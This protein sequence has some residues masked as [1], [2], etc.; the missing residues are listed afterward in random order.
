MGVIPSSKMGRQLSKS[1]IPN[2]STSGNKL[3]FTGYL[4]YAESKSGPV[5]FK[6]LFY[7]VARVEDNALV[8][9]SQDGI[10]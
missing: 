8:K 1:V 4:W 5:S 7:P 3:G 9:N 10:F 6:Y 2:L